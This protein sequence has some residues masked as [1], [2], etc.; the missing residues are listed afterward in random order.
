ML[1]V[2]LSFQ[3]IIASLLGIKLSKQEMEAHQKVVNAEIFIGQSQ[4]L[5]TSYQPPSSICLVQ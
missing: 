3:R 1:K 2:A 4:Q 5:V